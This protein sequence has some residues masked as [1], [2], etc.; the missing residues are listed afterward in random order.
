MPR[1][2]TLYEFTQQGGKNLKESPERFRK[3]V[4][5][6]E[7]MG[8][9]VLGA[10]YTEGPYD[11]VVASEWEDEE[12]AAAFALTLAQ[13]GNVKSTTMRAWT[14]EEFAGLVERIP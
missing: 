13:Q 2:V 10:H 3:A 6:A 5:R 9:E 7:S 4:E 12:A 1:Y 8:A 14:P 11:L